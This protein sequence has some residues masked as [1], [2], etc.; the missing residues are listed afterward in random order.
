MGKLRAV[1]LWRKSGRLELNDE[2][3]YFETDDD[4]ELRFQC[5]MMPKLI[6]LDKDREQTE[7]F[8]K[9]MKMALSSVKLEEDWRDREKSPWQDFEELM[10]S[11]II[12]DDFKTAILFNMDKLIVSED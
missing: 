9:A 1:K 7:F 2:M 12:S 5:Y 3:V 10:E 8:K 11:D 4:G 6:F